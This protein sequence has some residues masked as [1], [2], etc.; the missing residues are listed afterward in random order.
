MGGL[1]PLHWMLVLVVVVLLFGTAKGLKS[2]KKNMAEDD[3]VS[4]AATA[5]RPAG[6]IAAPN[7]PRPAG[8]TQP[9]PTPV[10]HV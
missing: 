7:A 10:D 6:S 9:T 4:M 5:E 1:S 3:D 8:Q 2:F